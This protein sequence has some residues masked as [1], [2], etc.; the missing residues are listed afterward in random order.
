MSDRSVYGVGPLEGD[1]VVTGSSRSDGC[2]DVSRYGGPPQVSAPPDDALT[3]AMEFGVITRIDVW[4]RDG[5]TWSLVKRNRIREMPR[6]LSAIGPRG[7]A[8]LPAGG[9]FAPMSDVSADRRR[10]RHAR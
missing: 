10:S 4:L 3:L 6:P 2:W 8:R 9:G 7:Y 1:V 5:D